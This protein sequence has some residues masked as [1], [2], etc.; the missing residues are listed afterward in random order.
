MLKLTNALLAIIAICLCL[1]VAKVYDVSLVP[2]AHATELTEPIQ[3]RVINDSLPCT[4]KGTVSASIGTDYGAG[5]QPLH[6]TSGALDVEV[7]EK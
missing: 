6:G 1:L 2:E 4:V 5:W 3:V 7:R